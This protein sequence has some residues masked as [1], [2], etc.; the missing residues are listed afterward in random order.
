VSTNERKRAT[1]SETPSLEDG[2]PKTTT[3]ASV[4]RDGI[5]RKSSRRTVWFFEQKRTTFLDR[6]DNE[7]GDD[8]DNQ[9]GDE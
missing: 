2:A 7:S 6:I 1:K 8:G 5:S 3:A 9:R 4:S